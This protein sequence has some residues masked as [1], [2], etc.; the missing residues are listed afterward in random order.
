MIDIVIFISGAPQGKGRLRHRVVR[1]KANPMGYASGYTPRETIVYESHVRRAAQEAMAGYSA[2]IGGPV[3]VDVFAAFP[4]PQ[5]WSRKKRAEALLGV[6]RPTVKPDADNLIK[7][8]F[9]PLNQVVWVDDKQVVECTIRKVY[10]DS[11]CLRI[12]VRPLSASAATRA[13]A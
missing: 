2:P 7:S 8:S 5:S 9:D 6:L 3:Q 13:A 4:V 12:T 1:S 11:P 10:S